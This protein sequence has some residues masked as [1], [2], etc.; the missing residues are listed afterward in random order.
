[1]KQLIFAMTV[2]LTLV[3]G[4]VAQTEDEVFTPTDTSSIR[5]FVDLL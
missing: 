2:I 1:M 3:T 4:I 5:T